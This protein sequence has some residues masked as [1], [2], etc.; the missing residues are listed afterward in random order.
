[1]DATAPLTSKLRAKDRKGSTVRK[2]VSSQCGTQQPGGSILLVAGFADE[3][4]Q[5][6]HQL[7]EEYDQ[8]KIPIKR[9]WLLLCDLRDI[10]ASSSRVNSTS[11]L[12]TNLPQFQANDTLKREVLSDIQ[13]NDG[14]NIVLF[15]KNY[16]ARVLREEFLKKLLTGQ[17]MTGS[18]VVIGLKYAAVES[19]TTLL[20]SYSQEF[21]L[22]EVEGLL[23]V[24]EYI[25]LSAQ[26]LKVKSV[27]KLLDFVRA[28][29]SLEE[30][31][32]NPQIADQ[33]LGIYSDNDCQCPSTLSAVYKALIEQLIA[34]NQPDSISRSIKDLND[35]DGDTNDHFL[36]V[37]KIAYIKF[38]LRPLTHY[39]KEE[40]SSLCM[41][42]RI[43]GS[44]S[45]FGLR[46]VQ[47]FVLRGKYTFTFLH[48]TIQEFLAAY[49]LASQPLFDRAYL[50]KNYV[51]RMQQLSESEDW[52][53]SGMLGF[54]SGLC[55]TQDMVSL[56]LNIPK[57]VLLPFLEDIA[58][59]LK[60][61]ED[62]Y[63]NK[64]QLMINCLHEA[65]DTGTIK[66]FV[67]KRP[68]M[69]TMTYQGNRMQTEPE[70]QVLAYIMAHSGLVHWKITMPPQ[71]RHTAEFLSMLVGDQL[72]KIS[73]SASRV[74]VEI[75]AVEG[76]T[77]TVCPLH[78]PSVSP[79][80]SKASIYSKIM[81]ELLHRLLQLYSPIKLKS[82]GSSTS[83]I[84]LL[85]CRCL[86]DAMKDRHF[87][88]FE[89]IMATHWLPVKSKSKTQGTHDTLVHMQRHHD[90]Q[91]VELVVMMT[92]YPHR[93]RFLVPGSN[94]EMTIELSSSNSP[95]FLSTGIEEHFN[96]PEIV[97][98]LSTSIDQYDSTRGTMVVPE[99]PLPKQTNSNALTVAPD[100]PVDSN[101]HN[102]HVHAP[103]RVEAD[104]GVDTTPLQVQSF[105]NFHSQQT[106]LQSRS[107][108]DDLAGGSRSRIGSPLNRSPFDSSTQQSHPQPLRQSAL[109]PGVVLHTR[110]PDIFATDVQYP[111][112]N[113]DHLVR[114]GGNGEIYLGIFGG[115]ELIIKKTSYRSRE[116]MIHSKLYHINIIELLCLM[117]GEKQPS[118]R[119]KCFCYHF[120]PKASG[121]LARL[122]I[123]N[124]HNTLKE[125]KKRY[126][127]DPLKY[128]QIQGNLKYILSQILQGL[129]YLHG[130]NIVHR[131]L[132]ASNILVVF[133]CS[134]TN[135][136]MCA[137]ANKCGIKIADFDSAI[138]LDE[139]GQ[140]PPLHSSR[141]NTFIVVPVGTNGYRPPECSQI[142][143]ATDAS[144]IDPPLTTKADMWSFGVLM[145]KMVRGQYGPS[146]QRE[147]SAQCNSYYDIYVHIGV[148]YHYNLSCTVQ[149]WTLGKCLHTGVI[150]L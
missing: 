14:R 24:F 122:C 148:M 140:L 47:P 55:H 128:G 143:I 36:A 110:I 146:S 60:V 3:G 28:Y 88:V 106:F 57:V 37:S 137:C 26:E 74:S 1:M 83:Y 115:K 116:Y 142:I 141:G 131:D 34:Q 18:M 90:G 109:K 51:V 100:V 95:D 108:I 92:P 135:P 48:L 44:E 82:D 11:D 15:A 31:C 101:R 22:F 147:V 139:S 58:T 136:L 81:R 50:L 91:H 63:L 129:V 8:R 103:D 73:V 70:L 96:F 97:T 42:E 80:K 89:P 138:E 112:P 45:A 20:D 120:L 56:P 121:D 32:R 62:P 7:F 25:L 134:C 68:G 77:F 144:I 46:L 43:P 67:S 85:G 93:I 123:D 69:F 107:R 75:E 40:F 53:G 125:L 72:R 111:L 71:K 66:K 94:S 124:E 41:N 52:Y 98:V 13:K 12:L 126:G 132:K 65:Q 35:L 150:C 2:A 5:V 33:V 86:E 114:K 64:K 149:I 23:D 79:S 133:S 10:L 76:S 54:F 84:S 127:H 9:K 113:E 59:V 39:S 117:M 27:D 130:L 118:Q 99:L 102:V 6:V 17:V 16:S 30:L 19:I 145:M 49:Y 78:P 104:G 21:Q 61:E 119:K 29:P 87:L 105:S 38:L 4:S